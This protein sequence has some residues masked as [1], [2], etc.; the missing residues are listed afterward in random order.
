MKTPQHCMKSVQSSSEDTRKTSIKSFRCLY[1]ELWEIL[2]II[3]VFPK[4]LPVKLIRF[5]Q[6]LVLESFRI[7]YLNVKFI[8]CFIGIFVKSCCLYYTLIELLKHTKRKNSHSTVIAI[9]TIYLL[10]AATFLTLWEN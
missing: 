5:A 7:F 8:T 3:L 4:Y 1:C 2:L 6:N 10:F 9:C